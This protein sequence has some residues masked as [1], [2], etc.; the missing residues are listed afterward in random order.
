[1]PLAG[2]SCLRVQNSRS[3]FLSITADPALCYVDSSLLSLQRYWESKRG[4]RTLP[5]RADLDPPVDLP[6]HLAHLCLIDVQRQPLRMRYRL[7]GTGIVQVLGRDSTGKWYHE[8]YPPDVLAQL[9]EQYRWMI[10]KR[11]PLR[12]FGRS[13]Y[14][15]TDFYDFEML[16]LPLASDGETVDM[17]LGKLVFRFKQEALR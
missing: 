2:G 12:T 7:V 5:S 3:P 11:R 4:D 10:S 15:D 6:E 1:M 9:D 8:L 16:S 17:V 14:E 13:V